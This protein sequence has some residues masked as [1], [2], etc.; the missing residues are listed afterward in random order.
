[1]ADNDDRDPGVRMLALVAG[2]LVLWLATFATATFVLARDPQSAFVRGAMVLLGVAGFVPW[3][4]VAAMAIRASNEYSRRIHVLALALA[5]AVTGLVVFV[6]DFLER[7]GFIHGMPTT[8]LW[9]VMVG[10]WWL[11]I[12]VATRY[13]R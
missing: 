13:Y 4:G 2:T 9:M 5:F 7:A 12:L 3:V 10:S 6:A 11:C 8:T 1:M